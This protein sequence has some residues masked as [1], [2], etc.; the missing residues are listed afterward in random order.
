MVKKGRPCI[1]CQMKQCLAPCLENIDEEKYRQTVRQIREFFQGQG[2]DVVASLSREMMREAENLN[3]E[4]AA[5]LRDQIRSLERVLTKQRMV[6]P[7][8]LDQDYLG[9]SFADGFAQA[10]LLFV[11]AGKLIG[12]QSFSLPNR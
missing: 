10:G 4:R 5:K 2:L 9:I 11:R 12:N 1:Y 6:S 3:F 7:R 8:F